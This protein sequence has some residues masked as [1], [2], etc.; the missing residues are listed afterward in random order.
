[1][2]FV[3]LSTGCSLRYEITA[4]LLEDLVSL[5]EDRLDVV[6]KKFVGSKGNVSS[7]LFYRGGLYILVYV[8][9]RFEVAVKQVQMEILI[10]LV[11]GLR[12]FNSERSLRHRGFKGL[13]KV[14]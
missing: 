8:M 11:P 14:M 4:H 10:A 2:D 1:M 6:G 3:S 13:E 12:F 5:G 7:I 9:D